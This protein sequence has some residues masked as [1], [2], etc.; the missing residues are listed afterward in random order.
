MVGC[1]RRSSA[2]RGKVVSSRTR[3]EPWKVLVI[4]LSM[5][6]T[7]KVLSTPRMFIGIELTKLLLHLRA[8]EPC[9]NFAL[10]EFVAEVIRI[11]F[12]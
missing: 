10:P 8:V 2:V 4:I 5:P 7:T 11:L 12:E 9:P 3:A 1:T 6:F